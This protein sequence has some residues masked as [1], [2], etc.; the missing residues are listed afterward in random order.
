MHYNKIINN[1]IFLYNNNNN[2]Y[3]NITII[4]VVNIALL[5]PPGKSGKLIHI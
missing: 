1:I 2:N 4:I 5:Y 3:I